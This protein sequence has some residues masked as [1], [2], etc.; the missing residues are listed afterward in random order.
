MSHA[1]CFFITRLACA[2]YLRP[3]LQFLYIPEGSCICRDTSSVKS[4]RNFERLFLLHRQPD[5]NHW[6]SCMGRCTFKLHPL[7]QGCTFKSE[8]S[9]WHDLDLHVL[10]HVR[11]YCKIKAL[12]HTSFQAH[13]HPLWGMAPYLPD[14]GLSFH[15][16]MW[17]ICTD[18]WS[19]FDI[20]KDTLLYQIVLRLRSKVSLAPGW[21]PHSKS[22]CQAAFWQLLIKTNRMGRTKKIPGLECTVCTLSTHNPWMRI[23]SDTVSKWGVKHL[24]IIY[25]VHTI[26][27]DST[28]EHTQKKYV[29]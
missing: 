15:S 7:E 17:G 20:W 3:C 6:L 1:H 18:H 4:N 16:I 10:H 22:H 29:Q 28:H 19:V 24:K 9:I 26:S 13:P 12:L 5:M 14:G 27:H 2:L 8:L 21:L 25:R 11:M 23:Q